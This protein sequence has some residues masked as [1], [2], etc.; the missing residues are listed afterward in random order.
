MWR[1]DLVVDAVY[2]IL[3]RNGFPAQKEVRVHPGTE[4]RM[5]VVTRFGGEVMWFDVS[6]VDPV[7]PTYIGGAAKVPGAAAGA[8]AKEKQRRWEAIAR[9][10]SAQ[11]CPLVIE[12]SGRLGKSFVQFRKKLAEL[13]VGEE[14]APWWTLSGEREEY[15]VAKKERDMQGVIVTALAC[16]NV[17][18]EYENRTGRLARRSRR[19]IP[20]RVVVTPDAMRHDV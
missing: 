20:L 18:V 5:D 3:R 12:T 8:R 9:E 17:R 13:V 15:E 1:H 2:K 16:G 6:V 7:A 11:F 4:K 14:K 10:H 19:K